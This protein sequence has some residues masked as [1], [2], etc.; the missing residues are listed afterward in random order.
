MHDAQTPPR[1]TGED[2]KLPRVAL[3]LLGYAIPAEVKGRRYGAGPT[4]VASTATKEIET[5]TAAALAPAVTKMATTPS[6]VNALLRT[7]RDVA[8]DARRRLYPDFIPAGKPAFELGGVSNAT[9]F[10]NIFNERVRRRVIAA[11]DSGAL[12][13]T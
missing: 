12:T 10:G 5:A 2:V 11:I 8:L 4:S 3:E 13:P 6:E 9:W 1:S 7:F